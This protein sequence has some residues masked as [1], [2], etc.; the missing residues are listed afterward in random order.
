MGHGAPELRV[1]FSLFFYPPRR[2]M[3]P[4]WCVGI[5]LLLSLPLRLCKSPSL[6]PFLTSSSLRSCF[7]WLPFFPSL[8]PALFYLAPSPPSFTP[9]TFCSTSVLLSFYPVFSLLS[10]LPQSF[11]WSV[12]PLPSFLASPSFITV[13]LPH[14][15]LFSLRSLIFHSLSSP[16]FSTQYTVDISEGYS[17]AIIPR[18]TTT[19]TTTTTTAAYRVLKF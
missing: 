19:T 12:H 1:L 2:S 3:P 8:S 4:F 7:L 14:M 10:V 15:L 9:F 17:H 11:T 16:N 18:H 13:F 6:S 5:S